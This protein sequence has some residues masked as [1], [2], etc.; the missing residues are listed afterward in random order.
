MG[1][2]PSGSRVSGI[3]F[4]RA[5]LARVYDVLA[6]GHDNFA[7]DRDEAGRLLAACPGLPGLV[8]ENRAFLDRAVTW[9]AGQGIAQ[10]LDLGTGLPL[11]PALHDS[12]RAVIPGAR[13]AY[14]DNDPVVCSRVGALLAADAG[15]VTVA[16]DVTDPAGPVCLGPR[17]GA[18]PHA[19][20][21]GP[22][23]RRRV[24]AARRAGQLRGDLMRPGR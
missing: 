5:N 14:V 3:D 20:R 17:P 11:R 10:F 23:G 24:C 22:R 8:R 12:A 7:A 19:R 16:A 9:A 6:G 1:P 21:A 13:V 4:S 15:V 18:R 2:V